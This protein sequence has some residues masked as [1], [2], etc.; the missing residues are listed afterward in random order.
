[1]AVKVS[2]LTIIRNAFTN[3]YLIAEVLDNLCAISDEVI[4]CDGYSTDG[5]LEYLKSRNDIKIFQD[6]WNLNSKNGLE[7]ANIT[8]CGLERCTGDYIFY[9]QADELIHESRLP[10]LRA[11][12]D[13]NQFNTI[14]CNFYH[15]RYDFDYMLNGGYERA[16]RVI[17][18]NC[19]I[20]SEYDGFSFLGNINP[21]HFSDI[22]VYHFGYVF[23][24]NIFHKMIN[25][26]DN[27]YNEA[28]NYRRRK[29]LVLDF[30]YRMDSGEI[31]DPLEVQKVLEPEYTLCR[32][33]TEIPACVERLRNVISYT[34]PEN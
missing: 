4:V 33:N 32:H 15:I 8:N 30:L 26:A 11:L 6:R 5:T 28:D 14:A 18:N 25:H 34:L 31:L 17:R 3:G 21:T 1:M 27:F 24:R 10:D 13:T 22:V 19:G 9:L 7:F 2:G 12:I 23:L 16:I 20:S 29:E